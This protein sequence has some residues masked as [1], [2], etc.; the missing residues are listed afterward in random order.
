MQ[1][2]AN[3]RRMAGTVALVAIPTGGTQALEGDDTVDSSGLPPDP[4][5]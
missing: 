5:S 1:A 2:G 4:C 3:L